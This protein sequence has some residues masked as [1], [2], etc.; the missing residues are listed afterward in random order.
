MLPATRF[1]AAS[2][3]NRHRP[4]ALLRIG[5]SSLVSVNDRGTPQGLHVPRGSRERLPKLKN[6]GHRREHLWTQAYYVGMAGAV[7]AEVIRRYIA[8]CQGK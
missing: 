6:I 7:S 5:I 4:C 2:F 8:E 1:S 3:G